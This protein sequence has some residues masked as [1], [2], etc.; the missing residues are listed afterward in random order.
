MSD[1]LQVKAL[2]FDDQPF[3]AYNLEVGEDHTFFVG[4]ERAWVHNDCREQ[5]I[6]LLKARVKQLA[7]FKTE[8]TPIIVD[9]STGIPAAT[10]VQLRQQG[11]NIRSVQEIFGSAATGLLDQEIN[12]VAKQIGAR[13]LASDRGRVLGEGFPELGITIRQ[14]L[15]EPGTIDRILRDAGITPGAP[16]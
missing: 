1:M 14:A 13:V 6:A 4:A 9:P 2:T 8:G 10:I 16:R 12:T 11:Y 7:G 3:W 15:R 5:V